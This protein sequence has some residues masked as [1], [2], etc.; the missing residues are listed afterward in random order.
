MTSPNDRELIQTRVYAASPDAVFRA[1]TDPG[2]LN[3]WWGPRGF[4]TTTH[5]MQ[6]EAGGFWR[7]TM[8]GPDGRDYANAIHYR[9]VIPGRLLRYHHVGEEES[10]EPVD[11]EVIVTFSPLGAKTLMTMRSTFA[12]G[13]ALR[14]VEEE[15][16]A[17]Q[18]MVETVERLAE[19]L[20]RPAH[21]G[22]DWTWFDI[23]QPDWIN[24]PPGQQLHWL[25]RQSGL[26][27]L[28]SEVEAGFVGPV[29]THSGF[30]ALFVLAGDLHTEGR[31]LAAGQGYWATPG[32]EHSHLSSK[33]GARFLVLYQSL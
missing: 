25:H 29:H 4:R 22:D 20:S 12:D 24:G 3:A 26:D 17:A 15:Y 32:S 14:R 18:G 7:F 31:D 1:W 30:E 33:G 6:V 13:E 16:G 5:S 19:H 28:Y 2:S 10:D 8:H 9:E 11:F 27:L 23:H 21:P